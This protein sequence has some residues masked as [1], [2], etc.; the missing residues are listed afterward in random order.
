MILMNCCLYVLWID[1]GFVDWNYQVLHRHHPD[2][3]WSNNKHPCG[4]CVVGVFQRIMEKLDAKAGKLVLR[5][6]TQDDI[7]TV[8]QADPV[9]SLDHQTLDYEQFER[10]ARETLKHIALDRGK[11]LGLFMIGGMLVVHMTKNAVKRIP[12]L[13]APLGA[14]INVMVPTTLVGPAVGV[15]GAMYL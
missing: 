5:T 12:L 4:W 8:V 14:F 7:N 15:A 3:F 13:G 6:V 1:D 11:R 10:F 2:G 9:L